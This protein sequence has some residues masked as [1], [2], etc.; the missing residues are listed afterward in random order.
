LGFL[1]SPQLLAAEAAITRLNPE[2]MPKNDYESQ[3]VVVENAGKFL[4]IAGET[5]VAPNFHVIGATLDEQLTEAFKNFDFALDAGHSDRDHVVALNIFFVAKTGNE[6][7]QIAQRLKGYFNG[8]GLPA[9][10]FIGTPALVAPDML[11]EIEGTAT[12]PQ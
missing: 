8:H 3:V 2:T 1:V 5:A 11:V 6:P 10:T 7:A 4:H 12:V 9:L